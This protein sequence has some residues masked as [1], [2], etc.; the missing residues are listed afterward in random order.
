MALAEWSVLRLAATCGAWLVGIPVLG[1]LTLVARSKIAALLERSTEGEPRGF[2][3]T[4][5]FEYGALEKV[6]FFLLWL[7]PPLILLLGWLVL[8]SGFARVGA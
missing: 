1:I 4:V 6:V 8:R 7:G 5:L 3:L 2:E